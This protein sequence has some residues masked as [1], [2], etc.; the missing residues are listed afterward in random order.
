MLDD[1]TAP[2][3]P[4]VKVS[5]EMD[6]NAA[7]PSAFYL[8][9]K[10]P[11]ADLAA[12]EVGPMTINPGGLVLAA[13]LM[14]FVPPGARRQIAEVVHKADEMAPRGAKEGD[15]HELQA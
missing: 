3:K 1:R 13:C 11:L 5:S 10:L 2:E 7:G 4:A 8:V 12:G 14:E 9:V 6:A 15:E